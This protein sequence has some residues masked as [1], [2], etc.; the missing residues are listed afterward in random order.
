MLLSARI[1][2]LVVIVGGLVVFQSDQAVGLRK[3]AYVAAVILAICLSLLRIARSREPVLIAFRPLLPASVGLLFVLIASA[4]VSHNAGTSMTNWSR[5][6]LPYFFVALLPVVGLDAAQDLSKKHAE[7]LLVVAGLVAAVGFAVDWLNRRG[8]SSLGLGDVM[9]ATATLAALGFAYTI[10]R[11]GLGPHRLRWL[12]ASTAIMSAMLVNGTRTNLFLLA[13]T[14][15]I[16]GSTTKLRVPARRIVGLILQIGAAVAVVVPALAMVFISDPL[17]IQQRIRGAMLLVTGQS[18]A[19]PSYMARQRS[20]SVAR[21]TFSQ[22]PWFGVGPGRLYR[23]PLGGPDSMSLDTPWL[24]PAKFGVI[25][26]SVL[27]IYLVTVMVCVRRVRKL[28]GYSI[29]V[30]AGRGWAAA[31]VVLV[32]F[33]PWIE[34]K[35][36][37]LALTL[38][39]AVLVATAREALALKGSARRDHP[40]PPQELTHWSLGSY[41]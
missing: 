1:R 25:G 36:F 35:G 6:V 16:V 38:Y 9:L 41:A 4:F 27:V 7:R 32:P 24:V 18:A 37:A 17:F 40:H 5:D 30:T 8:V 39:L 33:G 11:A 20:Y 15:G 2:F 14:A 22:F 13:A 28:A 34:D 12:L 26:V 31:L 21:S 29:V 3:Y 10:T 19:D 23:T